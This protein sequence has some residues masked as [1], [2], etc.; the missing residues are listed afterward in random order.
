V[1][2]SSS[3]KTVVREFIDNQISQHKIVVFSKSYCP[4]CAST[5]ALFQKLSELSSQILDDDI[6]IVVYIELD[7]LTDY[8]GSE[9]QTTLAEMTDGQS[10][11]VPSVWTD[12]T[13]VGGNSDVQAAYQSGQ[14]FDLL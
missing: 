2:S 1:S 11:T 3:L 4:Y 14:L 8:D 9:I 10:T 13:F 5:K 12:G 6:D 7:K